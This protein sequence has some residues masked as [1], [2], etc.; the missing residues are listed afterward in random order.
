MGPLE[1]KQA[2]ALQWAPSS[3]LWLIQFHTPHKLS[4]HLRKCLATSKSCSHFRNPNCPLGLWDA[5][6]PEGSWETTEI[7]LSV[8]TATLGPWNLTIGGREVFGGREVPWIPGKRGSAEE[9]SKVELD[10]KTGCWSEG[11]SPQNQNQ[12]PAQHYPEAPDHGLTSS[13]PL[14]SPKPVHSEGWHLF[15][16]WQMRMD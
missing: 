9:K 3:Q 15:S 6:F 12:K 2:T 13:M 7:S 4:V 16:A 8:W 11:L 14:C 5:D 1:R 10:L